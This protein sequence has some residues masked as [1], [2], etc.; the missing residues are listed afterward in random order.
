M[1]ASGWG[2]NVKD[3]VSVNL[4]CPF[5][6]FHQIFFPWILSIPSEIVRRTIWSTFIE[7]LKKP[8]M[9][10]DWF[11]IPKPQEAE[12]FREYNTYHPEGC[13]SSHSHSR[14]NAVCSSPGKRG[15]RQ[16]DRSDWTDRRAAS[17]SH[18]RPDPRRKATSTGTDS[19]LRAQKPAVH[20]DH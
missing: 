14:G 12:T 3:T 5:Y 15:Q 16:P 1:Q 9:S 11:E 8:T 17:H 2:S 10:A 6:P 19:H 4:S 13:C 20:S 18:Q 7:K